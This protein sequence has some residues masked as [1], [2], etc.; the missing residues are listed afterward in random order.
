V[1]RYLAVDLG[2]TSGRVTAGR[3]EG[4]HLEVRE[5]H[6]F[7]NRPVEAEHGLRWDVEGLFEATLAGLAAG[8]AEAGRLD[9]IATSTWGVDYGMVDADG[10]L[11]EPPGHYRSPD[12]AA[13]ERVLRAV[14]AE[15]LFARTGVLPQPINT[16][17]R[18]G[19]TLSRLRP[20]AGTTALLMP[21]LWTFRL[22]GERGAERTIA[23]TTGMLDAHT[24]D[25]DDALLERAGIDARVLPAVVEP[26]GR[27]GTLR[28]ELCDRLGV[29]DDVAVLRSAGHD[30][31]SAVAAVPG[32]GLV[33]YISSGTWSLAGVEHDERVL[34][35][36]AMEAGFTNE[37]GVGG[38][39]RFQRNLTGLWLLEEALRQWRSP[40][41]TAEALAAAEREGPVASRIDVG[42]PEFIAPGDVLARIAAACRR[43]DQA[44]PETLGEFTR[45]ILQ[46]LAAAYG[47]TLARCAELTGRPVGVV[48]MVGGGSRNGLLCRLTA[49]ACEREVLA[50]PAEATSLGN[51]LVQAMATGEIDSLDELRDVVRRSAEVVR[52]EPGASRVH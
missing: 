48:H 52:Y 30:T 3:L 5:V 11:L 12:P 24:G 27:A 14:P 6:R 13:R 28:P 42:D 50:G 16:V 49:E 15:E 44:V 46:S 26:G 35:P 22:A 23:G 39:V 20:P 4:G 1:G 31:A 47:E 38:R 7:A 17:F 18:L 29:P 34:D 32:D 51:L 41:T 2:A 37:L 40:V 25:W 43:S 36:A 19:D 33:A 10:R 9:G 45:C 21:D 8:C